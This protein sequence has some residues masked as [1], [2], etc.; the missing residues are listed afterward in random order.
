MSEIWAISKFDEVY[1]KSD[2]RK[3]RELKWVSLPVNQ[4][5]HGYQ[6]MIDD[7]GEDA[8]AIYGAWCALLTVAALANRPGVLMT[9]RGEPMK[10]T[11][12]SRQT[13]FPVSI[14]ERLF[15]WAT[16]P[17]IGWLVEFD[18]GD[19]DSPACP[20]VTSQAPR[21]IPGTTRQDKTEQNTTT[22]HT[23]SGCVEGLWKSFLDLGFDLRTLNE[24]VA[25]F[26]SL[27]NIPKSRVKPETA[28]CVVLLSETVA[29][30]L[31]ADLISNF[32]S[33]EIHKPDRYIRVAIGR[34][35]ESQGIDAEEAIGLATQLVY[36]LR[37]SDENTK[38]KMV[39][40]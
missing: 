8:P 36:H 3:H 27:A 19:T 14:F 40:S 20:G 26:R 23:T 21:D 32:R 28:A 16:D 6:C 22:H 35:L 37:E 33:K 13:G 10:R 24:K 30:D 31:R 1:V 9:S 39:T 4:S 15:A 38:T 5:S 7:H 25:K 29:P 34:T 12:I 11:H 18:P 17:K 2:N